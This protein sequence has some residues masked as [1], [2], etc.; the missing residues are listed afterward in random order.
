MINFAIG[1]VQME[2][3][4]RRIGGEEIPYFRTAEFSQIMKEN[5]RLLCRLA[6]AEEGAR[7]IFLTGSGT[8][9]MEAAVMNLFTGED[10]LLVV[11]GG[12]FG[13][14]FGKICRIHG[15]PHEELELESGKGLRAEQLA[16]YAGKGFTGLL[17]NVHE[18]STGVLYDMEL[19][20][21]FCRDNG[22]WLA[23]DAVSSFL[24]DPFEM[25]AWGVDLM[26]TGSQK[27]LALPPGM[28]VMVLNRRAQERVMENQVESLYFDLKD[29]LKDGERGQTPYTPA[30]GVLLQMNCRLRKLEQ[31]GVEAEAR[32][33]R[34]LAED[35]REGIRREELPLEI[36]SDS[37]S[38][39]ATP[40]HPTGTDGEG[41]PVSARR[42]FEILKD[43]YGIFVCPNGGALADAVFR[44][45]HI[46]NLT[47]EDN[48]KLLDAWKDMQRR[49]LL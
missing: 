31:A 35:L 6:R 30:V 8:A 12:S 25:E 15:I 48:R 47:K 11:N 23:V 20:S 24:A 46:G 45:G 37:L 36:A 17:I 5:E 3:E 13:A 16:P 2:E 1:P 38:A 21:R 40:L 49:G 18:T 39:A 44:V 19:V 7:A 14:R 9:A 29:Y 27:A 42:V 34:A 10:R 43:E 32:R 28:A 4:I 33:I 41:N 22:L 26:L